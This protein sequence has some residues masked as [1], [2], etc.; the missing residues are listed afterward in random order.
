MTRDEFDRTIKDTLLAM[1]M[2]EE[3][4]DLEMDEDHDWHIEFSHMKHLTHDEFKEVCT[5]GIQK[6]LQVVNANNN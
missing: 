5:M 4:V 6:Y 1:N 2:I 3:D